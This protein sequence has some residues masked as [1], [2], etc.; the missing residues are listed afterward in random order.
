[1]D[2]D[3]S[4][5]NCLRREALEEACVE[6]GALTQLGFIEADHRSNLEYS[7]SYPDRSVQAIYQAEIIT[8][9]EFVPA[10]ESDE[11]VFADIE[12]VPTLHHEW[13]RVLQAAFDAATRT[14]SQ[15][16]S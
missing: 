3:E 1:M 14:I 12:Q 8:V 10:F 9:R 2:G 4:A 5:E 7:G 15:K 6:L 16:S 11:R 13:N